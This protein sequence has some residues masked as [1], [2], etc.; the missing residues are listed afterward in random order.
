MILTITS[1]KG[2]VG[3][4]ATA[5]HLAACLQGDAPLLVDGVVKL[6]R[7]SPSR[8]PARLQHRA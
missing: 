4:T 8:S 3:K 6:A 5:L 2:G 1:F 7:R